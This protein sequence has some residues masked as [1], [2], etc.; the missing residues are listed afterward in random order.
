D[1]NVQSSFEGA[2]QIISLLNNNL[3]PIKI[4]GITLGA[5]TN[6]TEE[7]I[8]LTFQL[9]MPYLADI[10][11]TLN[12]SPNSPAPAE[13]SISADEVSDETNVIGL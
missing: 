1:Y 3:R 7:P 9:E 13:P 2:K 6:A 8:N 12:N 4:I 5:T 10:G 11:A